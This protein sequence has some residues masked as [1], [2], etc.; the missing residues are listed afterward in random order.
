MRLAY[1]LGVE[2]YSALL[3]LAAPLHPKAR[4]WVNGR[5]N[6]S[7]LL[8][9][10]AEFEGAIWM[11]CASVGE[12]EQG[13]P[14][15]EALRKRYPSKKAVVSFF[16]P[17]G[18]EA[19]KDWN[20]ADFVFYLPVDRSSTAKS[21]VQH[22]KP[23]AVIWVKYEFWFN[24]LA[25]LNLNNTP[26]FLVSGIF[27]PSQHFFRFWGGWFR[28]QLKSFSHCFVQDEQSRVLLS[29]VGVDASVVGD[30]RFD[31]VAELA[32][33]PFA[34]PIVE[35]FAK[36]SPVLVCGSTW[37]ADEDCI[38][39]ATYNSTWRLMLVPHELTNAHL[40]KAELLFPDAVRYSRTNP[41]DAAKANVLIVD[42][43]GM[44]SKLYRFA[45]VAYIGG[46]FGAGIH[47][48]AEAA[49]YG[50]P[51]VFGPR[52]QKF[53]EAKQLIASGGGFTVNNPNELREL[54]SRMTDDPA[55]RAASGREAKNLIEQGRGA[56]A[57][58][59]SAIA[60]HLEAQKRAANG[61]PL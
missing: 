16:S 27:R 17:S 22:L 60:E 12:F 36:L 20:G 5:A 30:T 39:D 4:L 23:S 11:H 29:S 51:V 1:Q 54:L 6:T 38:H 28:K 53:N 3:H 59:T 19:R 14:V 15:L 26:L 35:A 57:A 18:Y 43:M 56:T 34:D 2:A 9:K 37:P 49:A 50:I 7:A 21:L 24:I 61:S 31:R 42:R 48:T 8:N 13:K 10:L 40:E 32:A 52:F 33:E 44:L 47:N 25:A 55:L 45:H 58:I 41:E 46:G